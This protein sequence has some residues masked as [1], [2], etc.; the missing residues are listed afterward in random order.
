MKFRL[1]M[2]IYACFSSWNAAIACGFHRF[3]MIPISSRGVDSLVWH[4]APSPLFDK[5]AQHRFWHF[6]IHHLQ[7]HLPVETCQ[8]LLERLEIVVPAG[9]KTLKIGQ[10][11]R[12]RD[13]LWL[14]SW[15]TYNFKKSM[16][17]QVS[18]NLCKLPSFICL[19]FDRFTYGDCWEF[20]G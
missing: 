8:M 2:P 14:T 1:L 7:D 12:K 5:C 13:C 17:H 3:T 10:N 4:L 16:W 9:M 15:W 11:W 6:Q 19:N 20:L 18:Y